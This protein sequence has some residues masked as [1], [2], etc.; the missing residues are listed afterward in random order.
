MVLV[1]SDRLISLAED[2]DAG[3]RLT[4][5]FTVRSG[6]VVSEYFDKYLFESRPELLRLVTEAM[7]PLHLPAGGRC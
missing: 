6:Q 4:G 3:C 7:M 1:D 5:E 2:I